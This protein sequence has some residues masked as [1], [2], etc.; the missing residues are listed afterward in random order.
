MKIDKNVM[1]SG[2]KNSVSEHIGLQ[3]SDVV[4]TNC[5]EST[6]LAL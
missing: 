3:R 6:N 4:V 2:F 5:R 1:L